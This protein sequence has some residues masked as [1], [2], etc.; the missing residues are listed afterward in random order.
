MQ[1]GNVQFGFQGKMIEFGRFTQPFEL[2]VST[3]SSK[4]MVGLSS[5]RLSRRFFE[6]S[7]LLEGFMVGFDVP[8]FTIDSRDLVS[9]EASIAGHQIL[10][11]GTAIFVCEDLLQ[12]YEREIN[13]FQVDF[14][15]GI[16]F[17]CQLVETYPLTIA[18]GLLTQGN[19]AIG[20]ERHD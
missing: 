3:Q 7:I 12:E 10:N 11:T 18:F 8:S 2:D 13:T 17:K 14:Q 1:S 6:R 20:L 15:T 4:Q 9:G 5:H 16:R 19:L